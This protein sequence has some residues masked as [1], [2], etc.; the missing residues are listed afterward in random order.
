MCSLDKRT[1]YRGIFCVLLNIDSTQLE[2]HSAK[3]LPILRQAVASI[4]RLIEHDEVVEN[5]NLSVNY[6]SMASIPFI[7]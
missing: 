3:K 7:L 6:Q 5:Y 4:K 2:T 1:D